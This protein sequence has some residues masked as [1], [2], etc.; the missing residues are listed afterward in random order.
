[1]LGRMARGQ[2]LTVGTDIVDEIQ[3]QGLVAGVEGRLDVAQPG[4]DLVADGELGQRAGE[5]RLEVA[6][7]VDDVGAGQ[8]LDGQGESRLGGGLLVDGFGVGRPG[9]REAG[10][11][12]VAAEG[13]G[14]GALVGAGVAVDHGLHVETAA[15]PA[16]G[17]ER[18]ALAYEL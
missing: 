12:D 2:V 6:E 1:M 14:G 5:P 10:Q 8:R 9:Q 16:L 3:C 11:A 15:A 13:D 7:V 4:D 17:H 18:R